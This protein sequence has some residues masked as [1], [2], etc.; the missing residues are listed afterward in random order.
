MIDAFEARLKER[1][2]EIGALGF[3][4]RLPAAF[5]E[6]REQRLAYSGRLQALNRSRATRLPSVLKLLSQG[7]YRRF[8][9]FKSAI[10]DLIT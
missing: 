7:R 4:D 3:G 2:E 6:L 9:G 5:A 8:Q 1:R 10:K